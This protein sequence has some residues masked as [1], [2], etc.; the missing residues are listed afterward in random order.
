MRPI[1]L[2]ALAALALGAPA[3]A[4]GLDAVWS[5]TNWGESDAALLR[6]F[7]AR[8]T[9]L[10]QAID[11]GDAYTQLV[12]RRFALG[13]YDLIVYYQ[14]DKGT[15]G[16]KRI[17]LERPRHAVNPPAFRGVLNALEAEYGA[18]DRECG[19]RPGPADGYQG[20]AEYVWSRDGVVIRAIFRDTTLEALDGCFS[21]ACGLT[22]QLLLRVSP[23]QGD[24]AQCHPGGRAPANG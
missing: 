23:P 2:I 18:A 9:V 1:A 19:A 13:G 15:H 24:D 8:V 6:Q 22:G 21:P 16:L 4:Q 5:G 17:Q 7:G 10:P 3:L 11:F 12:S 20:A 14:I